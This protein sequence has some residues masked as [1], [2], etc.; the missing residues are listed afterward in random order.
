MRAANPDRTTRWARLEP[1]S[2]DKSLAPGLEARVHDPLWLLGRQWQFGELNADGDLGSAIVA[3]VSAQVVPLARYRPGRVGRRRVVEPFDVGAQPLETLVEAEE[4]AAR[5]VG[6]RASARGTALRTAAG[7]ARRGAL[8]RRVPRVVPRSTA[9]GRPRNEFDAVRA[10]ALC[11]RPPSCRFAARSIDGARLYARSRRHCVQRD[12]R[13]P[14]LPAT[15]AIAA[16]DVER[17]RAAATATGWRGPTPDVVAGRANAAWIRDRMEYAFAIEAP[18]ADG[19]GM[20][21]EAEE[22]TDGDAGLAHVQ[23]RPRGTAV[24]A[25]SARQPPRTSTSARSPSFQPRSRIRA[26]PRRGCGNSRTRASTSAASKPNPEDLGR[27][28]LAEFALVYGGDWLLV[29]LEAPAGSLVRI[30]AARRARHV[31]P[32]RPRRPDHGARAADRGWRMFGVSPAIAAP[33]SRPAALSPRHAARYAARRAGAGIAPS[34]SRDRRGA[35]AARRDGQH[36]LGG[37]TQRRR[38]ARPADGSRRRGLRHRPPAPPP[39]P[40]RTRW[41]IG[42]VPTSRTHWLPLLPQRLQP[43]DPSMTLRLGALPPINADGR[44]RAH[45]AAGAVAGAAAPGRRT[46]SLREEEVPREGARVSR[47]YQLARW[48]DGTTFLWLGRRKSVGRGEGSSGLRFDVADDQ[49]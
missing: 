7:G 48:F 9:A 39:R 31:R 35:A 12:G 6:A 41:P 19:A 15:P 24:A 14:A 13:P 11:G 18:A 30:V 20:L 4:V 2:R 8:R 1:R 29:P 5:R 38:A 33:S 23:R 45:R 47:A 46:S 43:D 21:L 27:M 44:R 28:L 40:R 26:C 17:V 3:E 37:R 42:C 16:A 32:R 10:P 25:G 22:Y 34:G 49:P 36:G